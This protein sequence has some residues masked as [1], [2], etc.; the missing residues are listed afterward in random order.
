M[1]K[2]FICLTLC[3]L[4]G[5]TAC[6]NNEETKPNDDSKLSL[7]ESSYYIDIENGLSSLDGAFALNEDETLEIDGDYDLTKAG[8]YEV[9]IVV[10]NK[11]G[12]KKEYDK[13]IVVD[14][15]D[16][17]EDIKKEDISN[18]PSKPSVDAEQPEETEKPE[19]EEVKVEPKPNP[20]VKPESQKPTASTNASD[21][22]L[23]GN[24]AFV[25]AAMNHV[26]KTGICQDV[27]NAISNEAG[28]PASEYNTV[29]SFTDWNTV[30]SQLQ[31]GDAIWYH[32]LN[33]AGIDHTAV[34]LGNGQ[35]LQG[36]WTNGVGVVASAYQNADSYTLY[37]YG[38]SAPESG[39][40]E[41]YEYYDPS[42]FTPDMCEVRFDEAS[43][44]LF[45]WCL[46]TGNDDKFIMD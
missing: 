12:E 35:C 21:Y 27:A 42:Q 37:R 16:K 44:A 2:V 46:D 13:T 29:V 6:S 34:Y 18:K 45:S 23:D 41:D 15:A 39:S 26:G 40:N 10:T 3:F 25:K 5:L 30:N 9:K 43:D 38:Y 1:K 8:K 20:E 31:I 14:S 7:E 36:N 19:K 24:N 22:G 4:L 11:A 28:Y 17:L 32:N 33:G